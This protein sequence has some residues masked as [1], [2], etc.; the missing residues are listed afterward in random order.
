MIR[1]AICAALNCNGT[2]RSDSALNSLGDE[3]LRLGH[4]PAYRAR[5]PRCHTRR[6]AGRVAYDTANNAINV[7]GKNIK[8]RSPAR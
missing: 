4:V 3:Q 6:A 8:V 5:W 7:G 1:L 2:R